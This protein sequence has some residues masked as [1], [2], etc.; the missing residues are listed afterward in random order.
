M[1]VSFVHVAGLQRAVSAVARVVR[2]ACCSGVA[3]II[4]VCS[5]VYS[6]IEISSEGSAIETPDSE[7]M[8]MH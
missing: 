5:G 7:C 1:S 4:G 2:F 3:A 6:S 8:F